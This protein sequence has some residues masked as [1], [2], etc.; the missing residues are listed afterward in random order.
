MGKKELN[1]YLSYEDLHYTWMCCQ[2]KFTERTAL[3]WKYV[4][5]TIFF[6]NIFGFIHYVNAKK[7]WDY[8]IGILKHYGLF[9]LLVVKKSRIKMKFVRENCILLD[10]FIFD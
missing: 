9:A 4:Y 1:D 7:A 2:K 5:S 10:L 6:Y 3:Q 8:S